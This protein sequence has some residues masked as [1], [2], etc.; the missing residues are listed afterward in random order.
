M[1][2]GKLFVTVLLAA[3]LANAITLVTL[4]ALGAASPPAMLSGI[5]GL[6]PKGLGFGDGSQPTAPS[7]AIAREW[8]PAIQ[9]RIQQFWIHPPGAWQGR[10]AVV[11]VQ[12]E[13]GGEVVP[14]KV[15]IVESSGNPTFDQ[16][17]VAAIYDASPLPVPNGRDF[18]PFRDF[19]LVM[20]P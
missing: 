5:G 20:R 14:N 6:L 11:N 15:R 7:R 19:D 2:A 16:S 12:L 9:E 10:A 8:V 18:E 3:L 4:Y 17:V 1:S 13:P